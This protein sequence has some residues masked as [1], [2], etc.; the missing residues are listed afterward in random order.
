MNW[1]IVVSAVVGVIA[2][3]IGSLIAPWVQWAVEK[4]RSLLQSRR[5]TIRRWR[6]FIENFDFQN[7]KLADTAT[8][9]EIRPYLPEELRRGME[10]GFVIKAAASGRGENAWKHDILDAIADLEQQWKLL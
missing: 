6:D 10:S 2:G 3:A 8:Y 5:E 1:D 9:S 4:R 7:Y